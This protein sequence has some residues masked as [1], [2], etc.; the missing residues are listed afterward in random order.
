MPEVGR[1]PPLPREQWDHEVRTM[2]TLFEG[3][4]AYEN[5]SKSNVFLTLARH[6]KLGTSFFKFSGRLLMKS[7]VD[8]A[9]REIVILRLA[10]LYRS[11]YEWSQH[12]EFSLFGQK[13]DAEYV[14][15][16]RNGKVQQS[17]S[18]G[19]LTR[20]HIEAVKR[21]ADDPIWT[22]DQAHAIRAVDQL[23]ETG[24]IDDATWNALASAHDEQTLLEL[25]F[26]IG[27]YAMLAWILNSI[28]IAPEDGQQVFAEELLASH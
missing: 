24:H 12:V 28:G 18:A 16:Y 20:E 1:I 14:E 26:F 15:A 2:F 21:S 17:E 8:P 19:I 11:P 22:D 10:Y 5:G 9:L 25:L 13:I 7:K 27:S 4:E 6:P 3:P 23:K